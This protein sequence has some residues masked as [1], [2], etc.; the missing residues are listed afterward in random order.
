VRGKVA[1]LR[2]EAANVEVTV[3]LRTPKG[4]IRKTAAVTNG[5]FATDVT[6]PAVWGSA[7]AA[8]IRGIYDPTLARFGIDC[9]KL[10]A[11]P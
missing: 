10:S 9:R 7:S 3:V 1:N 6:P 5:E 4:D 11:N 2:P 8:Q